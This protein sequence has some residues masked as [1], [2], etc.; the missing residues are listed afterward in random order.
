[1]RDIGNNI[2]AGMSNLFVLMALAQQS[3]QE[4]LL[5]IEDY[6]E[7]ESLFGAEKEMQKFNNLAKD[8]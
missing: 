4:G 3:E 7:G 6:L 5:Y 8:W 2:K 1:M